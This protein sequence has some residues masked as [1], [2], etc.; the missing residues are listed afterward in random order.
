M[1]RRHL[2]CPDHILNSYLTI[3]VMA[4]TEQGR[5]QNRASRAIV[6]SDQGLCAPNYL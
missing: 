1:V 6:T 2:Y 4:V 3:T 5:I